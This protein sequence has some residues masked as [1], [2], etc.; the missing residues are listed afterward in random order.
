MKQ[1]LEIE[2]KGQSVFETAERLGYLQ[3]IENQLD[4]EAL[5]ILASKANASSSKKI[6]QF[7]NLI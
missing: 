3:K 7:K 1:K 5:R 4:T 2:V 6:K